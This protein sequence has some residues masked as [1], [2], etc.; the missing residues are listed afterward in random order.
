MCV[1]IKSIELI[2]MNNLQEI[3][4]TRVEMTTKL[5]EKNIENV[6]FASEMRNSAVFFFSLSFFLIEHK[7]QYGLYI[8][9]RSS[10]D[11]YTK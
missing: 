9:Q 5:K 2:N 4:L 7:R 1:K 10:D 8:E 11:F 6:V 3:K